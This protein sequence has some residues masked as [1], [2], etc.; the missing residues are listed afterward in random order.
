MSSHP[1]ETMTREEEMSLKPFQ[2][3]QPQTAGDMKFLA[4]G[5]QKN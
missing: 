1:V 5:Y 4:L 2:I 3:V